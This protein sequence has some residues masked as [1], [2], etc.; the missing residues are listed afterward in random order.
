MWNTRPNL[1]RPQFFIQ[2]FPLTFGKS[3]A[4]GSSFVLGVLEEE[5]VDRLPHGGDI[6]EEPKSNKNICFP[7][8]F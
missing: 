6:G 2:S 7:L 4:I 8:M 1:T 5:R 3:F